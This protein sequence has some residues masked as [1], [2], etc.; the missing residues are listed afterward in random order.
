[1]VDGLFAET[2]SRVEFTQL[3]ELLESDSEALNYYME[4]AANEALIPHSAADLDLTSLHPQSRPRTFTRFAAGIAAVAALVI[5]YAVGVSRNGPNEIPDGRMPV[6]LEKDPPADNWVRISGG[7]GIAWERGD[8]SASLPLGSALTTHKVNIESGIL[9]LTYANGVSVLL[10]GPA[11]YEVTGENS[12]ALEYGNLV[13]EVPPGAEGFTVDFAGDRLVDHGTQFGLRLPKDTG[14]PEVAVFRGEVEVFTG[15]QKTSSRLTRDHA[16]RRTTADTGILESI[17]LDRSIYA[18]ELP[19][20]ELS[21]RMPAVRVGEEAELEFDVSDLIRKPGAY[22]FLFKWMQGRDSLR[23]SSVELYLDG[24][25]VNAD[26]HDGVTGA[27]PLTHENAYSISISDAQFRTGSWTL[28]ATGQCPQI[29]DSQRASECHG[30]LLTEEGGLVGVAELEDCIGRWDYWHD[31]QIW[32]R[33]LD[34]QG[35]FMLYKEGEFQTRGLWEARDGGLL[36]F[37]PHEKVYERHILRD[38]NT[39]LFVDQ[40]FRNATR[41]H[42]E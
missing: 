16:V 30:I 28:R 17:P 33:D 9:E 29:E 1:M 10:E 3:E 2:L 40:P 31:G 37:F 25:L 5:A 39:L 12:G 19:S 22:L 26:R 38:S 8:P 18:R 13:A 14:I 11:R 34:P 15:E 20:R 35:S 42:E 41:I 24:V 32:S 7:V 4:I 21:W 6:A 36:M 23:L 27:F